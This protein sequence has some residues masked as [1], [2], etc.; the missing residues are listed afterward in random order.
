MTSS[1]SSWHSSVEQSDR[2]TVCVGK[3]VYLDFEGLFDNLRQTITSDSKPLPSIEDLVIVYPSLEGLYLAYH[4]LF[5]AVVQA[6]RAYRHYLC[7][8]DDRDTK[9]AFLVCQTEDAKVYES[10]KS[11]QD[12]WKEI[13]RRLESEVQRRVKSLAPI[14]P[15]GH[16]VES[17]VLPRLTVAAAQRQ[18]LQSVHTS[19]PCLI[20]V[21]EQN[22]ADLSDFYADFTR[23]LYEA[24][25][26]R[27]GPLPTF[28]LLGSRIINPKSLAARG[29]RTPM[30][31][32]AAMG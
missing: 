5:A 8:R 23:R 16:W 15:C 26:D 29:H 30:G 32:R 6:G 24:A 2:D 11:V 14:L 28:R 22:I 19:M 21:A 10:I 3:A 25:Q 12:C 9:P 31:I 13:P 18:V 4:G 17:V 1:T 7:V 27:P 20:P